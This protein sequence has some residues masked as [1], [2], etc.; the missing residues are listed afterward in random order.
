[1]GP[2]GTSNLEYGDHGQEIRSFG[3]VLPQAGHLR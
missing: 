3:Q 1:M 2:S